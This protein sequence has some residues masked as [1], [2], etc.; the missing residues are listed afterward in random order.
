MTRG[1]RYR[2]SS[3][4]GTAGL[5]GVAVLVINHPIVQ[6]AFAVVP[7]FGNPA[8]AV[9]SNGALLFAI[10]TTLIVT[11]AAMWPLFKPRPRRVLDTIL[12]TQKRI[13]LA[14]VGLAALGYFKWSWALPRS[15]L[16]LST[17][18]LL[19]WLP[20]FMVTIRRQPSDQSRGVIV[21]DDPA[22]MEAI[23][24]T[25]ALPVIGYIT[26]PSSYEIGD[27]QERATA[28][29]A[30]GGIVDA[31][32]RL[33][34]LTNLGGLSRLEEVIRKHNV[35]TALL[36]FA[37]TDRAEF[38]GALDTC[39]EH[40]VAVKVHRNHADVVLTDDA[41]TGELVDV[42]LEPW[43]WQDH[44][45]KRAFDIAFAA[46]G[47]LLLSP[48]M[49]VIAV[50]ITLEDGGPVFYTQVRTGT[51][52]DT[53]AVS[54][55]RTMVPEGESAEPLDDAVNTR[56]TSIGRMLR[57]THLDEI[58]QL[59]SIFVGEMSVV[60]PRAAWTREEQLIEQEA[61]AWRMRWFVKPGLTGL[62]QINQA[63]STD[64]EA[65]LR[66]DLRYIREQ[67]FWVDIKIVVRQV[68]MVLIDLVETVRG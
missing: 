25:T 63:D 31:T 53:F 45:L 67:S 27:T 43:D 59:W 33:D 15:T 13:L 37:T 61:G 11:I 23:L 57:R 16:M 30:D 54:K 4:A 12:L 29:I 9:L 47:L 28:E 62:A 46:L 55:F 49:A 56:I 65:K 21:G 36:A 8:P 38:F 24:S 44:V 14:M 2:I 42:D 20:A 10:S 48:V 34:E 1:W 7:F 52:G 50:A 68:W 19:L 60:G 26:P 58:P 40:G 17:A 5:T 22:A 51:F 41:S 18:V 32:D 39:F 35:D 6:R 66:Y 3:L 64:P